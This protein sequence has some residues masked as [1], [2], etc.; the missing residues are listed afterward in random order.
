[1][2]RKQV[3]YIVV[4]CSATREDL[5]IG[6]DEINEWHTLQGWIGI[7]YHLVIRRDGTLEFG[8]EYDIAGAHARGYN[9]ESIGVC[10]VGGLDKEG[11]PYDG[12]ILDAFTQQQD[13]TLWETLASLQI[14]YPNAVILG[15]RDLSPDLNGD[16]EI[17]PD[18][19]MKLCPTFDVSKYIEGSDLDA[20]DKQRR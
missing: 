2:K 1:M 15:H 6:K 10:L 18:E 8:R 14:L 11:K 9:G 7:G 13:D 3:K 16:G 4:H 5:D 20:V 12:E 17:T 19:Y